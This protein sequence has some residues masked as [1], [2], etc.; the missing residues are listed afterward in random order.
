MVRWRRA[1]FTFGAVFGIVGALICACAAFA[2]NFWL[3]CAGAL[4]LLGVGWNFMFIGGTTLL[5]ECNT[6]SERAKAQ[7][8]ND[9]A[10]FV[11][12]AATFLSSGL[13]F[14]WQGWESMN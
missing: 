2:H 13:L 3:L 5:T 12:M 7:G 10:I 6:P 4:M 8:A 1:G 11:T 14:T 9:L